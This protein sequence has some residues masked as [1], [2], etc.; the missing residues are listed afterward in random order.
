MF[1]AIE[2]GNLKTLTIYTMPDHPFSASF[3]DGRYIGYSLMGKILYAL[4]AIGY[5]AGGV[6][7]FAIYFA[8]SDSIAGFVGMIVMHVVMAVLSY[9][10]MECFDYLPIRKNIYEEG[11]IVF[12]DDP[13]PI[14]RVSNFVSSAGQDYCEMT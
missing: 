4:V 11:S 1:D 9:F 12:G 13:T 5:A 10:R 7:C 2:S 6:Y 3:G 8:Y 14:L